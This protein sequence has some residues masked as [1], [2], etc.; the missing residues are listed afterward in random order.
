MH[1]I[2]HE[3]EA[4]RPLNR[5]AIVPFAGKIITW[6][7]SSARKQKRT[8]TQE[9]TFWRIAVTG[10]LWVMAS[11]GPERAC[12]CV[13]AWVQKLFEWWMGPRRISF[14]EMRALLSRDPFSYS[15]SLP[16]AHTHTHKH[17]TRECGSNPK[18]RPS[19]LSTCVCMCDPLL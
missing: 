15:H 2:V 7:P 11:G 9:R 17:N 10:P 1:S 18:W 5:R 4:G 12:V 19:S 3:Y 16:R 6:I 13:W 14:G 8:Q